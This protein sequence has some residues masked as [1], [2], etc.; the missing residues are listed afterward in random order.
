[1][2]EANTF[3][4]LAICLLL[5]AAI[6][7]DF[8]DLASENPSPVWTINLDAVE[9]HVYTDDGFELNAISEQK[10]YCRQALNHSN[11]DPQVELKIILKATERYESVDFCNNSIGHIYIYNNSVSFKLTNVLIQL[12]YTYPV[13]LSITLCILILVKYKVILG[14]CG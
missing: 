5:R 7:V 9:Q 12:I 1:M 3:R 10:I 14:V 8:F 13:C 2:S 4:T 6:R 11:M